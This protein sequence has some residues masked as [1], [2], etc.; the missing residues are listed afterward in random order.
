MSKEFK[1]NV[2]IVGKN[3]EDIT[4]INW[5]LNKAISFI[6]PYVGLCVRWVCIENEK[7]KNY[8]QPGKIFKYQNITSS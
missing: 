8:Y 7:E 6:K 5:W 2:H 4:R 1:S 3:Q